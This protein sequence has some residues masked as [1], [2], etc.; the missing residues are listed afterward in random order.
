MMVVPAI[1][2][3]DWLMIVVL[4]TNILTVSCEQLW[5]IFHLIRVAEK[6]VFIHSSYESDNM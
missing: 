5:S 4:K 3:I 2:I 6:D 1:I